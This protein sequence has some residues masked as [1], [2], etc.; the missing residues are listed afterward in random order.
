ML[1]RWFLS[2]DL[3]IRASASRSAGITGVSHR[4][5]PQLSIL[6]TLLT[7]PNL[8]ILKVS[9]LNLT[10]CVKLAR[11]ELSPDNSVVTLI[12]QSF[13]LVAQ[14]RVQ[15]CDLHSLQPST[16]GFKRFFCLS[17]LSSKFLCSLA[18]SPRLECSS[19]I[20]AHHNLRLPGSN[21]SFA[22]ASQ[23]AGITSAHHH[24]QLIFVFVVG[25][26]FHHIG[27]ADLEL[28]TSSDP[29]ASASQDPG[30]TGVS[31]HAQPQFALLS[32]GYK[33]APFSTPSP[34]KNGVILFPTL[35]YSDMIMAHCSL[36][37]EGPSEPSIAVSSVAQITD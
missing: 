21:D 2:F 25:T 12:K 13:T 15:W 6:N 18:L 28:L 7:Y 19:A 30:I 37:L 23:V 29:S 27:Q 3:V 31:Y 34:A 16:L 8:F 26:G 24:A 1:T 35:K 11:K 17:L 5:W 32:T 22:S 14:A 9:T 20:S 33:R 36:S 4:A 10:S